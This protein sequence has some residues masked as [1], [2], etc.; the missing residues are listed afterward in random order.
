MTPHQAQS[1]C[2]E[3]REQYPQFSYDSFSHQRV[4]NELMLQFRFSIGDELVFEPET[5]IAS[6]DQSMIDS[7]DARLLERL[8][9]HLGL[10]EML[11]YWK[12]TCSPRIVIKACSLNA[13]QIAWWTDL[14]LR[15]MAEFFY[16]NQIAFRVPDFVKIEVDSAAGES[17]VYD[18]TV[19]GRPLVMASGGKDSALTLQLMQLANARF[20]CLMLNPLPAAL[21]LVAEAGCRSPI[22][23]RRTIDPRLLELNKRGFLNGHTPFS[24]LLSFLGISCAVLFGYS[25]VIVSNE[26]SSNEGN[27]EFLGAQVNHQYSKTFEFEQTFREYSRRYLAT[28]VDYFSLLRP[29][30]EIQIIK[31]IAAYPNLLPIFKSCNRNQLQG[32]WCGR[33]PKCISVFTLFYP[34][35]LLR[36]DQLIA[37]F[38]GNFFE[39]EGAIPMLKQLAGVDGHKPFECV[40]THSETI[41]A[42]FL[43]VNRAR[44]AK[45][46]LPSALIFAERE[47]LPAHPEAADLARSV[48]ASWSGEHNLP[49]EYERLLRNQL[50]RAHTDC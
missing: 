18:G 15:G 35:L 10:V 17:E 12:A 7:I 31:L 40:G 20:N 29:L 43:A 28:G 1:K 22:I 8:V 39:G 50:S 3:L 49:L 26:R 36:H 37:A 4:G 46:D 45:I 13:D 24:A 2:D 34:F 41:A 42:L 33:C 6:M 47:I 19:S 30:Y 27:V 48:P 21:T 32:S 23:V 44:A 14:L 16:V 9:F 5:V 38:G 25:R 11:S